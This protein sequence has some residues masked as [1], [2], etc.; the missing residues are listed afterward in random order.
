[1]FFQAL[2]RRALGQLTTEPGIA[3]EAGAFVLT[4]VDSRR[5]LSIQGA[6]GAFVL[7]GQ[8]TTGTT[9]VA[10][11][12]TAST[13]S[14]VLGGQDVVLYY[15]AGANLVADV[16]SFVLSGQDTSFGVGMPAA[17]GS[18]TLTGQSSVRQLSM[19]AAT[20]SFALSGS[21]TLR[22]GLTLYAYNTLSGSTGHFLFAPLG[23]L[24]LGG[25]AA[26]VQAG[27]TFAWTGQQVSFG[28]AATLP[29]AVGSF[30]FTFPTTQLSSSVY[31]TKIRAFPRVARSIRGSSRGGGMAAR[32][33]VGR[34][35][36]AR[37]FGG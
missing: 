13:G 20:G 33:T 26:S 12:L 6:T 11:R 36:R 23:S 4:G 35:V 9:G 31:P 5:A 22:R 17:T 27:T 15:D 29:A 2:G 30:V 14:F 1:M 18:F 8:A 21:L 10:K 7:G 24:S 3:V 19:P 37:A 25:S 34:T 16:G 28:V 32:P